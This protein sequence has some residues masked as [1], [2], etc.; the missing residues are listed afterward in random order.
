MPKYRGYFMKDNHIVAPTV[1][2]ATEDAQ[3]MLRASELLLA[4][5]FPY[6]EVWQESRAVGGLSAPGPSHESVG[7][8]NN[9][10]S[11]SPKDG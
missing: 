5:Q 4:S 8:L 10:D 1:I 3:A 2:E 11:H 9:Q 7:T 6:I